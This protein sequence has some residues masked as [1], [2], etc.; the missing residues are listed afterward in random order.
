MPT[1]KKAAPTTASDDAIAIAEPLNDLSSQQKLRQS[2]AEYQAARL[3]S[4]WGTSRSMMSSTKMYVCRKCQA[5][6]KT[7]EGQPH[8]R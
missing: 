2:Q 6:F 3:S 5:N 1:R 8:P 7:G 4:E